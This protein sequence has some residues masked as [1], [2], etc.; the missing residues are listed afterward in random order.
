MG[1][2]VVSVQG[3][4]SN[5]KLYALDAGSRNSSTFFIEDGSYTRLGNLVIGYKFP[6]S[7]LSKLGIGSFRAYLQ[8]QNLLTL[9][10]YSGVDPA[11]SN[12]NIGNAGNVNDLR[13]GYDNGNYPSNKIIT[14]GIN[15]GF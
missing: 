3:T 12:A 9:T 10:N 11:V 13:T 2:D 4:G 7:T 8:G 1:I 6:A 14:F 5:P 15:L